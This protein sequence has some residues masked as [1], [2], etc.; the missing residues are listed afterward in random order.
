LYFILSRE[1]KVLIE[2]LAKG[3]L[4][5]ENKYGAMKREQDFMHTKI[6]TCFE[7]AQSA[8]KVPKE[9][10][11]TLRRPKKKVKPLLPVSS[12]KPAPQ[13]SPIAAKVRETGV[14]S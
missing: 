1:D 5:L 9:F 8:V 2:Q 12:T 6:E 7:L 3:H 4:A 10:R 14:W 11:V 13:L